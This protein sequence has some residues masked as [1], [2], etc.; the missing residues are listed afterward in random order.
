MAGGGVGVAVMFSFPVPVLLFMFIFEFVF[1]LPRL[2][3]RPRRRGAGVAGGSGPAEAGGVAIVGSA[4]VAGSAAVAGAA[5][6]A[7][8]FRDRAPPLGVNEHTCVEPGTVVS[9][10]RLPDF[11]ARME[12]ING[13]LAGCAVG[14][15]ASSPNCMATP[16]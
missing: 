9:V 4:G 16:V 14:V 2:P 3:R 10:K 12:T 5:G 7:F 6:F 11:F 15:V 8:R 1:V 13:G